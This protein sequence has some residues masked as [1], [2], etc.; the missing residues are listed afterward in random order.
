M[1]V[2][3]EG[4]E[5][6]GTFNEPHEINHKLRWQVVHIYKS[7]AEATPTSK[8]TPTAEATPT[9]KDTSAHSRSS[10]TEEGASTKEVDTPPTKAATPTSLVGIEKKVYSCGVYLE[11]TAT[12]KD[13]R[14]LFI[15]SNQ[16]DPNDRIFLFLVAMDSEDTYAVDDEDRFCLKDFELTQREKRTFYIKTVERTGL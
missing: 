15:D 10:R 4:G 12:L 3:K 16:A 14:A 7:M 1:F 8:D 5:E 2:S 9:G 13:L 11:E 6:E